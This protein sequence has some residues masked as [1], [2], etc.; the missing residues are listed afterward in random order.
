MD[1]QQQTSTDGGLNTDG[2]LKQALPRTG[3]DL[4][5]NL[6]DKLEA[7]ADKV[8]DRSHQ[9]PETARY[10]DRL[11]DGMKGTADWLREGGDVR[12]TIERHA[13]EKPLRTLAIAL[14]I[15]FLVGKAVRRGR[16][17]AMGGNGGSGGVGNG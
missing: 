14:G 4:K 3:K 12:G 1:E 17:G 8:R 13:R 9:R 5:A 7:G 15:G 11:A 6:A 10:G 2:G 16:G